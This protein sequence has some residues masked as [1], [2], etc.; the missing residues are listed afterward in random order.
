MN[1]RTV[2]VAGRNPAGFTL[3][4]LLVVIA[5]VAVL[6]AMLVPGLARGNQQS[7]ADQCLASLRQLS[8]AWLMYNSDNGGNFVPNGSEG[9]QGADNPLSPDLIPGGLFAQWC[10]GRQDAEATPISELSPINLAPDAPNVGW[11]WIRAGLIYRYVNNV[12]VYKCP[13]DQSYNT[14]GGVVY[15]HVRSRSMNGWVQPLGGASWSGG[16][17]DAKLRVYTKET[18]LTVPGAANTWLMID[19][20]P[21]SINDAWFIAD[22]SD[23]SFAGPEWIDCPASYHNNGAGIS[24]TDGHVQI[25]KWTDQAILNNPVWTGL[26]PPHNG[27]DCLWLCSRSTALKTATTFTGPP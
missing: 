27:N 21:N 17:D 16:S 6:A 7:E 12:Q 15:P 2:G 10:P 8:Q 22:P 5:V 23:P 3:I 13:S 4:E 18:D 24:F 19:E 1:P 26:V 11:E 9:S 20:N 14:V 25:K